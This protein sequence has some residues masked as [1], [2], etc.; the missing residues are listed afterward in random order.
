MKRSSLRRVLTS[1][2]AVIVFFSSVFVSDVVSGTQEAAAETNS[3]NAVENEGETTK[4][5][6]SGEKDNED[7]PVLVEDSQDSSVYYNSNSSMQDFRDETIYFVMITRFYDGDSSN[8]VH[9]WDGQEI[10]GDDT[11]WRGD[12][13][14]LIEKLDYIKALG[15]TALWITPIVKNASGYDYHGYHAINFKE[16][17]PRYE[18]EGCTYQDLINAVHDKGMKIIQDVVFNHT[19]NWGEE[20]LYPMFTRDYTKNQAD[21]EECMIL[22]EDMPGLEGYNEITA[23]GDK[24]K[25]TLQFLRRLEVINTDGNT[26]YDPYHIYHHEGWVASSFEQP[27]VQYGHIHYADCVDLDTENPT[28]YHYLVDAYSQYIRM[29]VDAFRIDTMKHISRL[30]FNKAFVSQLNDVYNEVHGTTGVGNFF[31]F[32]EVCTRYR[33]VWNDNKPS[34]SCPFYTWKETKDYPWDDSESAEAIATNG[35]SAKQHYLDNASNKDS[36]PKSKNVFLEGNDYHT[37]DYSQASGMN[38]IDFPMHWAFSNAREAYQQARQEDDYYNDSSFNITYVDSHDYGPDSMQ[39]VRYNGTTENWAENLNLMFTFRG[40]PC[41]YYGSEVEFKKGCLIDEGATIPLENSG[42]AYFGDYIEGSVDVVDFARYTNATGKMAETLNHPLSLHIQRLNRLRAAIPALRKGQYSTEGCNGEFAYKRRYTDSTTDSFA[43]IALSSNATFSGIPNGKYTD[44]ISGDVQNVTNGSLSTKEMKGQ[45]DLRV[46]V[47]DT[48]LTKAPGMIDGFSDFMSGGKEVV[49]N[50]V[51]PTGISLDKTSASLDLGETAKFTA[52]VTPADAT[53]K[54]V[55]WK[56]SDT[57]VATVEGNGEVTARGEGTATIYAATSNATSSDYDNNSGLVAKATVTV[58]AS[59]VR[60]TSLNLSKTSVTL[61]GGEAVTITTTILPPNASPK[62]TV[63][64]WKSSDTSVAKVSSTGVITGVKK[65]TATV[66]ATTMDGVSAKV[67]VEVKGTVIYGNA[68]Y[69]EKPS[70]WGN[71]IN[72]YMWS[73]DPKWENAAWPGVEMSL[74]DEEKGIYGIEWPE[75]KSG[76]NVVFNDG[77]SNK[78]ND[79]ENAKMNGYYNKDG[80]VREE[81]TIEQPSEDPMTSSEN[82][83][84]SSENPTTSS[85]NTTTSRE[86]ITTSSENT[87][88]SS[89]DITTSSENTTTSREDSTTSKEDPTEPPVNPVKD[90]KIKSFTVSVASGMLEK[91]KSVKLKA[92]VQN[93]QGTAK[94]RFTVKRNNT[95][96]MIK[97]YST[98]SYVNWKPSKSGKYTLTVYVKDDYRVVKKSISNFTVNDKL[99]ISSFKANV[100]SKKARVGKKIKLTA[101]AAGGTKKYM[102]KYS[103]KLGKTAKTISGYNKKSSVNWTP[104]KAGTYELRVYVKDAKTGKVVKKTIKKYVVKGK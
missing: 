76:V 62:Y 68:I 50:V 29:G 56:S 23:Q 34:I 9:C 89:E 4:T 10:N 55:T 91:G 17:D 101:K 96:T 18:S 37:P 87:T 14:G 54:S 12:F 32:G 71:K 73:N 36:Q 49:I 102:Y 69:F 79:L 84:T 95:A 16:V 53:N 20:N 1:V 85:E 43:L 13:K 80:F 59:G 51:K 5:V 25:A 41:I 86:D 19:G 90:L 47:L 38:V 58:K 83:T 88:T 64:T 7:T 44:A 27:I 22:N 48:E 92:S 82:P 74:I 57:T 3:K 99:K 81:P 35:A 45:G 78:T 31:M 28:V 97:N 15:F 52:T 93:A 104:K 61:D 33:D 75:G 39:K 2:L 66:T 40:I 70:D 63:L 26:N 8:N 100:G 103:Y 60:V 6:E 11:P 21:A 94:Y 46:Y 77:G 98:R 30:T 67:E 24:S 65:G 72:M 42:R